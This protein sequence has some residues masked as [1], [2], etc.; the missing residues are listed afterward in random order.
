MT[1][2]FYAPRLG[3]ESES[4]EEEQRAIVARPLPAPPSVTSSIPSTKELAEGRMAPGD[5][6]AHTDALAPAPIPTRT[7]TPIHDLPPRVPTPAHSDV[8]TAR[9]R[10]RSKGIRATRPGDGFGHTDALAPAPIPTRTRTP[11]HDPPPR[12]PTPA[13]SDVGPARDRDRSRSTRTTRDAPPRKHPALLV[14][15][16]ELRAERVQH[17]K[18]VSELKEIIDVLNAE[19][20]ATAAAA[21][22]FDAGVEQI[23]AML[24][25]SAMRDR[26]PRSGSSWLPETRMSVLRSLGDGLARALVKKRAPDMVIQ[27]LI[28][29]SQ[30]PF[31]EGVYADIRSREDPQ[32]AAKWRALTRKHLQHGAALIDA[33]TKLTDVLVDGMSLGLRGL[34][35]V[36]YKAV[37][38]MFSD[39]IRMVVASAEVLHREIGTR[40]VSVDPRSNVRASGYGVQR[41]A[42]EDAAPDVVICT[43]GLGIVTRGTA[44][45][46]GEILVKPTVFLQSDLE[47]I[48]ECAVV[49]LYVLDCLLTVSH[50]VQ[51]HGK[52]RAKCHQDSSRQHQGITKPAIRRLARRGR[53]KRVSLKIF[54]ENVIRDSVTYTERAKRRVP[55]SRSR[56]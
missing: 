4:D 45:A 53:V 36:S 43:V 46:P 19:L 55:P 52:G 28:Q 23:A 26:L 49:V 56:R 6:F 17:H 47:E 44:E 10:D 2:V 18:E 9:D 20:A 50:V 11:I 21:A 29:T 25:D 1:S 39:R 24:A 3:Y 22:D 54:L 32:D 37:E 7:R 38:R 8:G 12:A 15:L 5:G 42:D 30:A 40:I 31:W 14:E 34:E 27:I 51:G 13:Q 33:Q 35:M 48:L 41:A 16:E